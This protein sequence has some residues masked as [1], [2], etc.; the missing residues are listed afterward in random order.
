[1]GVVWDNG[2]AMT[3]TSNGAGLLEVRDLQVHYPINSG[4][5]QKQVG[6]VKAVDHVRLSIPR[7]ETLGLVGESGCGKTGAGT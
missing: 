4:L 5:F 2:G 6:A 3:T 7:G 1:M